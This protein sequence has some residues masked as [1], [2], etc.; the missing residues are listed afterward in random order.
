MH[1][2]TVHTREARI[3]HDQVRKVDRP[4]LSRVASAPGGAGTGA[5]DSLLPPP[6]PTR[7]MTWRP[8]CWRPRQLNGTGVFFLGGVARVPAGQGAR[9]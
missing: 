5:R 6:P 4:V 8:R 2:K 3:M 1:V 9:S 7:A